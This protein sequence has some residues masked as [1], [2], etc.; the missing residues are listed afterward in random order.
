[1]IKRLD[2]FLHEF[3]KWG[4]TIC[5]V[6]MLTLTILN[7]VLRWFEVSILWIEPLVRHLVFMGAF[8]GGSL[9]TGERHHIKIDILS[10]LLEK[11][12]KKILLEWIEIFL[13]LVTLT[14][15]IVILLGAIDLSKIEFEYGKLS[16]LD[17]HSGYLISIIPAG[18]A[19][20]SLR[21]FLR[22]LILS[23]KRIREW[24]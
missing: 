12:N 17:I 10:R 14:A 9:A 11:F 21:L 4:V 18:M 13:T 23:V 24:N 2:Q 7:I 6:F 16:F 1:M 20:I 15:T 3:S 5:V 22:F 8:F 19:L